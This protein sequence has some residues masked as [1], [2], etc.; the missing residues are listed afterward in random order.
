MAGLGVE[1]LRDTG[2]PRVPPPPPEDANG[3]PAHLARRPAPPGRGRPAGD[4]EPPP[5]DLDDPVV[6]DVVRRLRRA[7]R[8]GTAGSRVGDGVPTLDLHGLS[9]PDSRSELRRFLDLHVHAGTRLVRVIAGRGLHSAG[10]A[11]V[12]EEAELVLASTSAVAGID[13]APEAE[14]GEGVLIVRLRRRRS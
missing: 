10:V 1:P 6:G 8:G 5:L 3:P 7:Q 13:P 2:R 12:R 11:A 9:V 14:G 4:A